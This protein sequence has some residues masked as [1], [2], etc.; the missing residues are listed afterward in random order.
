[1]IESIRDSGQGC[2]LRCRL[3]SL[4]QRRCFRCRQLR[5]FVVDE[6]GDR[7]ITRQQLDAATKY[8]L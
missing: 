3:G 4:D 1:M 8:H 7:I 5:G 6:P 2:L